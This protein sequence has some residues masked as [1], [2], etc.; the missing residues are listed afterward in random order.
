MITSGRVMVF[1]GVAVALCT[2]GWAQGEIS[3][4][5]ARS[6]DSAYS[7][8]VNSFVSTQDASDFAEQLRA[9]GYSPI[10]TVEAP[11]VTRVL[12]GQFDLYPEAQRWVEW[13]NAEQ[14]GASARVVVTSRQEALAGAIQGDRA[15]ITPVLLNM[16]EEAPLET[17]I[18]RVPRM[19]QGRLLER[20]ELEDLP[21]HR[22]IS[23][24]AEGLTDPSSPDEQIDRQRC[25]DLA[26]S[27]LTAGQLQEAY[28][29]ISDL[30]QACSLA[31][32]RAACEN[33]R[34]RILL[35]MS[36]GDFLG[37]SSSGRG[38]KAECRREAERVLREI[39]GF[40]AAVI[41]AVADIQLIIAETYFFER[42]FE[43][44]IE[45]G[46]LLF[47]IYA[48]NPVTRA[49]AG[50]AMVRVGLSQTQMGDSEAARH[51]YE[52]VL[53]MDLPPNELS[54]GI[55]PSYSAAV[56]L[57]QVCERLGDHD[58]VERAAEL[59]ER[60]HPETM[61]ALTV[62]AIA[63]GEMSLAHQSSE[64]STNVD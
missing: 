32:D 39:Q 60:D 5:P 33:F 50:M 57:G 63:Q 25:W 26:S 51:A 27:L 4:A 23:R 24:M 54:E 18:P 3:T 17:E 22:E 2:S 16:E 47:D 19:I 12:F 48:A 59:L 42:D 44:V 29:V 36:K 64:E 20:V 1:L 14:E 28:T 38:T 46:Q 13:L 15:S 52:T 55:S 61:G 6:A 11:P 41:Q 10:S 37:F 43:Q 21:S 7:V 31:D 8:S 62:R 49:T 56:C 40:S 53:E 34:L 45:L 9:A 35:E 58:G 30:S